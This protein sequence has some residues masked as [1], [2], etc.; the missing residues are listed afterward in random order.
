MDLTRMLREKKFYFAAFAAFAGILL[1]APYPVR[2]ESG[3]YAAGTFLQLAADALKSQIVRFLLPLAAVLPM[4]EEY[5]RERQWNFL[6]FL[7][8]RRGRRGYC[9]DRVFTTLLSGAFV[10][11]AAAAMGLTAFFLVFFAREEA[12]K[13]LS[14]QLFDFLQ[15]FGRVCLIAGALS[16]FSAVCAL[17]GKSVYLAFGLPF[18]TFYACTILR[19]RYLEDIYCIDPAEWIRAENDWCGGFGLWLF[20]ILLAAAAALLHYFLLWKNLEEL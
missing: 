4:G 8:I 12:A 13:D 11:T 2:S 6:R 16:S 9:R 15:V 19:E 10:W 20:L 1:G 5:L 7:A 17:L 14:G 18:L 3:V